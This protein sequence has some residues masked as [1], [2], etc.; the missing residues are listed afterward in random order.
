MLKYRKIAHSLRSRQIIPSIVD[1]QSRRRSIRFVC[2]RGLLLSP[3]SSRRLHRSF[4]R[5]LPPISIA[6][7]CIYHVGH[8]LATRNV[9]KA[10][11]LSREEGG[12]S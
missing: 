4:P 9:M 5:P 11:T 2:L 6:R 1:L 10:A 3:P 7:C 8:V 12:D